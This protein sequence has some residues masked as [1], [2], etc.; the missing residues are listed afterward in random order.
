MTIA[1]NAS[2]QRGVV[3]RGGYPQ[4]RSAMRHFGKINPD[5]AN[6]KVII[7]EQRGIETGKDFYQGMKYQPS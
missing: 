7:G 6:R 3:M 2:P 1:E 5:C 4:T